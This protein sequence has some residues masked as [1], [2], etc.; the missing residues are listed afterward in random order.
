M[1]GHPT[2]GQAEMGQEA[3]SLMWDFP[4]QLGH[5]SSGQFAVWLEVSYLVS[6]GH[7][8]LN[9]KMEFDLVSF[10]SPGSSGFLALLLHLRTESMQ[11]AEQRRQGRVP[12]VQPG[13]VSHF[14]HKIVGRIVLTSWNYEHSVK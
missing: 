12:T 5:R 13:Q 1:T 4:K 11:S 2:L 3:A 14:L 7:C 8:F 10:S 9:C 6:L